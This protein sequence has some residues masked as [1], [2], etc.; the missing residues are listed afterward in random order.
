MY[1]FF[2]AVYGFSRENFS[3][4]ILV[5]IINAKIDSELPCMCVALSVGCGYRRTPDIY[6]IF[7]WYKSPLRVALHNDGMYVDVSV[8]T[9]HLWQVSQ[10][11]RSICRACIF[12]CAQ[13]HKL[14]AIESNQ[15]DMLSMLNMTIQE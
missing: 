8:I 11:V 12:V 6:I 9:Q 13:M 14:L 7:T 4:N 15:K 1:F 10:D 2:A 3:Q 5:H